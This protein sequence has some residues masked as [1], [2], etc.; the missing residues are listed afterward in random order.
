[1]CE[2]LSFKEYRTVRL[3]QRLLQPSQHLLLIFRRDCSRVL[4]QAIHQRPMFSEQDHQ[5]E[6]LRR[7]LLVMLDARRAETK[8]RGILKTSASRKLSQQRIKTKP[9]QPHSGI[10]LLS[11]LTLTSCIFAV[12]P[13]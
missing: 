10:S 3:A 4:M 11:H 13:L 9:Q 2:A 12:S 6:M 1:M 7:R 5:H 8:K